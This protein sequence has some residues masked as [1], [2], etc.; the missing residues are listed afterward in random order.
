VSARPVQFQSDP[1]RSWQERAIGSNVAEIAVGDGKFCWA[2]SSKIKI[3][4]QFLVPVGGE[5][6]E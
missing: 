5:R 6:I 2:L 1:N 3:K 4:K